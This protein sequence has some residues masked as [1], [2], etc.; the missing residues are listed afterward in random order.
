MDLNKIKQIVDSKNSDFTKESQLLVL[1]AN[2]EDFLPRL[3]EII[4][5]ERDKNKELIGELNFQ[6]SRADLG[7]EKPILNENSFINKEI[8]NFY[9]RY[10]DFV[11]HCFKSKNDK[12]NS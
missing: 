11:G 1:F 3:L 2:S 12:R 7:L 6:L 4:Q 5:Y 8:S 9:D 10:E